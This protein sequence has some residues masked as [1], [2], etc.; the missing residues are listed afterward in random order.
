MFR[1]MPILQLGLRPLRDA[2][3]RWR[4]AGGL[5][6]AA[7][8]A[9][10]VGLTAGAGLL[11]AGSAVASNGPGQLIFTPATGASSSM[12]TWYTTTGCPVG[13]RGSAQM[14]I[15]T[16]KGVLISRI[17]PAVDGGLATGFK[18]TLDGRLSAILRFAQIPAGGK[19][20]FAMGCY[21]QLGGTGNVQ[22]VQ[23]AVIT[24][25]SSGTSYSAVSS[26]AALSVTGAGA[27]GTGQSAASSG[28][29]QSAAS[30]ATAQAA[31]SAQAASTT[32]TGTTGGSSDADAAWIAVA[33]G[34]AVAGAG[35][36]VVRR[37][38]RSRLL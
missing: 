33:C 4:P 16:S 7:L 5:H 20:L 1:A 17:S 30:S 38:N 28:T 2:N 23:S 3:V 10:A 13:Y 24:L 31:S 12:P 11:A 15:F 27:T 36:V 29:G 37:R 9:G 22:W 26:G 25:S 14:S 18:G 21:S 32:A 35:V 6:R 19:L 34:L 8:V